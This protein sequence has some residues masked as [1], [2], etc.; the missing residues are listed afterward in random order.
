M[1]FLPKA[2]GKS[3]QGLQVQSEHGDAQKPIYAIN[4]VLKK[5]RITK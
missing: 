4:E 5:L 1:Q 3:F 2:S